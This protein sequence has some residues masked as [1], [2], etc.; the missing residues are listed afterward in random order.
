MRGVGETTWTH[1]ATAALSVLTI[2]GLVVVRRRVEAP[3]RYLGWAAAGSLPWSLSVAATYHWGL[4]SLAPV[5]WM[6]SV[7]FTAGAVLIWAR[8]FSLYG[9]V[10][11]PRLLLMWLGV[12]GVMLTVRVVVG[13][14]ARAP[15]FALNTVYAFGLLVAAA[16]VVARRSNDPNR[17]VRVVVGVVLTGSVGALVAEAL[18]LQLTDTVTVVTIA[19]ISVVAARHGAELWP[20]PHSEALLDDLGA[21]VFV[22][23]RDRRLV[24]LNAPGRLFYSL[25]GETPPGLG[26]TAT[27]ILGRDPAELD[28]VTVEL[29]AG[30]ERTR[31]SGYVQ[32]LPSRGSPSQGWLVLLRRS[33]RGSVE[34]TRRDTR[35]SSMN[36]LAAH[37]PD[38]GL[39]AERAFRQALDG[40][41]AFRGAA[42]IPVVALVVVCDTEADL[43]AVARITES[44]WEARLETIAIGRH[45]DRG[46][47]LVVR[48]VTLADVEAWAGRAWPDV[49]AR[50]ATR[51]GSLDSARLLVDQAA[52]ARGEPAERPGP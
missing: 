19:V 9:W 8:G 31:F 21:L 32:R 26:T 14:P 11:G 15:I 4:D 43:S 20:R 42:E 36:R 47:G 23:D 51:S 12:S 10:P 13:A 29:A 16:M 25:R 1:L 7:A 28:V 52:V 41:A 2:L 48:D 3:V 40:A 18:R 34:E 50:F 33:A 35:R 5:P 46:V 37:D 22:F 44:A 17:S 45:G 39:P 6:P 27:D 24:D 30:A 38:T 49:S